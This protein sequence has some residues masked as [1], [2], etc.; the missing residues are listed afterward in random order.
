M[1]GV[2]VHGAAIGRRCLSREQ[3]VEQLFEAGGWRFYS[4]EVMGLT[5]SLVTL[6]FTF[7]DLFEKCI[8]KLMIAVLGT[9]DSSRSRPEIN[10]H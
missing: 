6:F 10:Y 5:L 3:A 2:R 4:L 7:S 8:S 1:G 9:V